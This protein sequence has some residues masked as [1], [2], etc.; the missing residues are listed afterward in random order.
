MCND[1]NYVEPVPLE[2]NSETHLPPELQE[3]DVMLA[4]SRIKKT[5]TGPD[6]VPFWVWKDNCT[7][8]A[9]VVTAL[10]NK[11]LSTQTWPTAWKG[12]NINPLPKVDN[13]LQYPDFRGINVT[14]VIARCFETTIYHHYNKKVFEENLTAG[15][16]AYS[17]CTDALIQMQY[18]Y[19]KAFDDKDCT[20]VRLLAM[21]FSKAFD[22][23]KHS[24]VG[25]KLKALPLNPYVVNC[26]VSKLSNGQKKTTSI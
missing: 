17:S 4:L 16:Y 6:G 20:Y 24:L 5:A 13:P 14:P 19:L 8:L 3:F 7:T 1:E 11:S 26:M 22:N 9:P 15:Q 12:A 21:D 18:N 10:W 2:V 23:V 25:E